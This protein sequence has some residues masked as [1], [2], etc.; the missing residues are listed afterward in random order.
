MKLRVDTDNLRDALNKILTVID[1]KNSRPILTYTLL[2]VS[3]EK[4]YLSATD[5]EV[6]AKYSINAS[7]EGSASFC[8]NAK[9][10]F[11]ILKELPNTD[12]NMELEEGENL[13][14]INCEDIHYSLLIYESD[15]FPNL[16][17]GN[18]NT[19]NLN[20]D[21]LLNLI[22]KTSYA[23]SN[24]ETR[25]HFNGIYFQEVE[26]KLRAVST[27]GH[28][29]SLIEH[30]IAEQ[31]NEALINGIIIP[32]KGVSELRKVAET[33]PGANLFIS[34]DDSY[35][36]VTAN[37]QYQLGIRLIAREY[38]KYQA[39]I[40]A[41]TTYSL[42]ADK[43]TLQHAIRRIKIMSNEK[44]NAVKI[45]LT[46]NHMTISANHPSLGDAKETIAV[47]YNGKEL[48]IGFNAR[49]LLDSIA[50]LN[51]ENIT[52]E[53][54]NEFSAVIVRSNDIQNYLGIIMPLRI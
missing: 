31:N 50:I 12:I 10:L 11:D 27:D 21:D 48:E 17:F 43:E 13:L 2:T 3:N 19:F 45:K 54:N 37:E 25:L 47:D 42:T 30:D 34:V 44:S 38:P 5:L 32:K 20:S 4:I 26:G 51:S 29:L 9:N 35:L 16:H 6:S 24:D 14:K 15:E 33:Y 40:P 22:T 36:Y 41:K 18:E 23:I 39:V 49:F 52:F 53:F 8:I 7:T 1:K 46:E 28:R